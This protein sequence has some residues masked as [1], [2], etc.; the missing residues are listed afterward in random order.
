M[1]AWGVARDDD[2]PSAFGR[3]V[4]GDWT[5]DH[6]GLQNTKRYVLEIFGADRKWHKFGD[7]FGKG[8]KKVVGS[9]ERSGD[10]PALQTLAPRHFLLTPQGSKLKVQD[11][12]SLNGVFRKITR[13]IALSEGTRFR[14]GRFLIE[15]RLA[16]PLPE[17]VPY[18]QDGERLSCLDPVASAFLV[19]IRPD[20]RPGLRFPLTKRETVLGQERGDE[21]T[22]IDIHLPDARTSGR[23]AGVV[24]REDRYF[25]ENLS[26]S[27]GTFVQIQKDDQI[28]LGDEILAGEVKFRVVRSGG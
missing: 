26:Q 12:G 14:I 4:T 8:G 24:R 18:S 16:G 2:V 5:V 6:T 15:F 20:G 7:D 23:H 22:S 11:L 10:F 3:V 21:A 27:I 25:L 19:F 13:P 28:E 9:L 17:V 1:T